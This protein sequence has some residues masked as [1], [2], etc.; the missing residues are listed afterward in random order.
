M[1]LYINENVSLKKQVEDLEEHNKLLMTKL[2][3]MQSSLS[4]QSDTSKFGTSL[5][6]VVFFIAVLLGFWCPLV[7]K[8]QLLPIKQT[9]DATSNKSTGNKN[10]LRSLVNDD[11][12]ATC[13]SDE[14]IAEKFNPDL[15]LESNNDFL[16]D[17]AS[18]ENEKVDAYINVDFD[19][20]SNHAANAFEST[21]SSNA[22]DGIWTSLPSS[23]T[24][25][26]VSSQANSGRSKSG[27]AVELTKVRPFVPKVIKN[28]IMLKNVVLTTDT[29]VNHNQKNAEPQIIILNLSKNMV[30]STTNVKVNA[31]N[32]FSPALD[33]TS[34]HGLNIV[35]TNQP[36]KRSSDS[37][38]NTADFLPTKCRFINGPHASIIKLHTA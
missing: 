32:N 27:I 24:K 29:N 18:L 38:F 1:D 36:V 17:F 30:K 7:A 14:A 26:V 12:K 20:Q 28:N 33:S 3:K 11:T 15:F 10:R 5:I 2:Q 19:R 6:V 35:T 31:L 25:S 22:N 23:P 4:S 16:F 21:F 8:D 34:T 37:I 9:N 13:N